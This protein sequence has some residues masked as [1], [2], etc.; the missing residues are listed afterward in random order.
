MFTRSGWSA[1]L[2]GAGLA[3]LGRVFGL[4]EMFVLA[5]GAIGLPLLSALW[6]LLRG[7]PVRAQRTIGPSR[8]FAGTAS[9]IQVTFTNR[10]PISSP[11]LRVTDR[12]GN[13][14]DAEL[15]LPPIRTKGQTAA[16]YRLPVERRG[17]VS[18]GPLRLQ[19]VDPF[20]LAR[21]SREAVAPV[22]IL[23]YPRV[24]D[25]SPPPRPP[26]DDHRMDDRR[27][28][29]LGRSSDE[30]FA[31]RD[32]VVG[33]DLRRVH[34][35]STARHDEMMVRQ[36]ELPQQGRTTVVLD[37]RIDAAN[38]TLFEKMV[39]AAAS[40]VLA[41]RRRDDLVRLMTT[42]GT[43]TGFN[44]SVGRDVALDHLATVQQSE[45]ADL[46]AT[47]EAITRAGGGGSSSVVGLIGAAS[48]TDHGILA[49]RVN[50]SAIVLFADQA[51]SVEASIG[52][53]SRLVL[54]VGMTDDFATI[55]NQA[56][57]VRTVSGRL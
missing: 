2:V 16:G 18:V 8:L 13:G 27:A 5:G 19:L 34:W 14:R 11:V 54:S 15:E 7:S 4:F 33:D 55:W 29:H 22:E 23:V 52:L 48:G 40:I 36:D 53:R 47:I 21:T 6:V 31:L 24:D 20:G 57:A 25:V 42:S 10:G 39:S 12:L 9:R 50:A 28:N 44:P 3:V 56:V 45:G 51:T 37:T 26:G 17:V 46:I 1:L 49:E 30:F 38:A 35:P 41:A 43:D 32:Y